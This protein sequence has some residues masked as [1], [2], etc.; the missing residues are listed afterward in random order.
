DIDAQVSPVAA[1]TAQRRP[2]DG[3]GVKELGKIEHLQLLIHG[4]HP[5]LLQHRLFNPQRFCST[6]CAA[7][8][9]QPNGPPA[10]PT[11]GAKRRPLRGE[12]PP[13][14]SRGRASWWG[15][16]V[17]CLISSQVRVSP[18]RQGAVGAILSIPCPAVNNRHAEESSRREP[19]C[20]TSPAPAPRTRL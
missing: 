9:G 13:S 11:T 1:W 3:S 6:R 4:K 17:A 14:G 7:D 20:L 19:S 15:G 10:Q 2:G 8:S 5:Q 16:C 18:A 12:S